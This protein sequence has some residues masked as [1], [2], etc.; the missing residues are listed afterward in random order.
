M[1][2][3]NSEVNNKQ[4]LL[5]CTCIMHHRGIPDCFSTNR[6]NLEG[7]WCV[8][9]PPSMIKNILL[10]KR[11]CF[12]FI[13]DRQKAR[14]NQV[15]SSWSNKAPTTDELRPLRKFLLLQELNLSSTHIIFS[16]VNSRSSYDDSSS[17]LARIKRHKFIIGL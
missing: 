5:T 2:I 13:S 12:L 9:M 11:C 15:A 8:L 10:I 7:I 16:A 17:Y 3:V 14:T 6:G 4:V 1:L